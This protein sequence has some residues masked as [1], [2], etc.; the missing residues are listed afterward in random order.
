MA[1]KW[2]AKLRS[3]KGAL[4]VERKD[5]Y[6][7]GLR[8]RS[9]SVNWGFG[10]THMLPFGYS[11]LLWG[12]PKSG[13]S[14][15]SLDMVGALHQADPDAIVIKYDAEMRDEGQLT[16]EMAKA[17]EIDLDRLVV[18]QTNDPSEIFDGFADN[19]SDLV[20]QG[21]K[22]RLAIIDS[23]TSVR[24][25]G[26]SS[27]KAKGIRQYHIGDHAITISEGLKMCIGVQREHDISMILTAQARAQMDELEQKR[28]GKEKAAASFGCLH[29]CELWVNVER[30]ETK[31]GRK[32]ELENDLVDESRKDMVDD[33]ERTGHKIRVWFQ[34][35]TMSGNAEN[36]T[37]EFTIDYR[38]GIINQHEEVYRLGVRWGIVER[39]A[40]TY[41]LG[42]KVFRGKATFLQALAKDQAL[43]NQII[44]GLLSAEKAGK[45][46]NIAE[47]K[48]A[49]ELE[50]SF[51]AGDGEEVAEREKRA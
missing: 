16:P 37:A 41:K 36:R 18:F 39:H 38:R 51:G 6:A 19:V 4:P 12:K 2:A 5:R 10:R 11:M 9:P 29:H 8:T 14:L 45:I 46:P 44:A 30:N 28:Y 42:D 25:R 31:D 47:F 7:R 26:A 22:V 27:D 43:Q 34:G 23:V 15:V 1:N 3:I 33:A 20:R 50:A 40:Q 13:K 32:D 24:G 17:W 21:A 48:S 35:N 49:E